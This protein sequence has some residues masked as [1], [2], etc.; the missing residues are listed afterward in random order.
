[1]SENKIKILIID[2]D[3]VDRMVIKRALKDSGLE[4]D[5]FNATDMETGTVLAFEEE[6]ACIFLDYSLPGNNGFEF[7]ENYVS[8][9]GNS[10]VILVTSSE[11][12]TIAIE[13]IKKGARDF[14]HK[15]QITADVIRKILSTSAY[16]K[17]GG[18]ETSKMPPKIS[19]LTTILEKVIS[20]SPIII[21]SIDQ[22]GN[23]TFLKGNGLSNL[24][25][26][27]NEIIGKSIFDNGLNLPMQLGDYKNALYGNNFISIVELG[28]FFY[29][30]HYIPVFDSYK[31]II[32]MNGI[33]YNITFL[34]QKE[35]ELR[36]TLATSEE[37][38]K[39][40]DSFLANMSHEVRTPI[41]GI[42]NLTDILLKT[43]ISEEQLKYLDAIKKSA[44]SLSVI[45]NDILDLSKI[46]AQK[47]RFENA[48]FNLREIVYSITEIFKPRAKEKNLKLI[49]N[50]DDNLSEFLNGDPVRLSQV[51]NNLLSNAIKFTHV[52]EVRMDVLME[53]KNEKFYLVTFRVSDTG[54]GIPQHK[55]TSIFDSFSQA[56]DDITRKYGG[57]GLGLN[58]CKKLVELQG[59]MIS[60]ESTPN[61]GSSF[62]FKL[63]F[64]SIS[65]ED[66][67][68]SINLNSNTVTSYTKELKILVVE[69]NDINRMVINIMTRDWNFKTDNAI[70]GA[71]AL[72][73]IEQNNYDVVLMDIEMPGL[74]GYQTAEHIRKKLVAPKNSIPILAMTAHANSSEKEK[75][76]DAGM[77]DYIS[78]PFEASEL[79]N[80]I[81]SLSE[82]SQVIVR[83]SDQAAAGISTERLTNLSFLRQLADN[84]ENFF[85]DFITLFLQNAPQ[86]ISDL[87]TSLEN[88]DWKGVRQA[89][90][91]IKPTLSY[92]GMKEE[93]LAAVRIEE[94]AK[95]LQDLEEIPALTRKIKDSCNKA[96]AELE[97]ELKIISI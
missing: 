46:E 92:L 29:Q 21:F 9:K 16:H 49:L 10:P 32:G 41:H 26:A 18:G 84:N 97:Q 83:G 56:G 69:D 19:E 94:S 39:I 67:S 80:K 5:V 95:N 78:K 28:N 66:V 81:I 40:K 47:M 48:Q 36:E 61:K 77:N 62:T 60:V 51:I 88:K 22:N 37:T 90:H 75:C 4:A 55:L 33:A 15:N 31:I 82:S 63:P 64:E 35:K 3:D 91:K 89:A 76:L 68:P 70:N 17:H 2:D 45:I 87:S 58:I 73:M 1:M 96:Y 6:F 7:L 30:V 86:T 50:Y 59:G 42:M 53:E 93:H 11:D 43:K 54:I 13:A 38:Q 23:F 65:F 24:N 12:E 20:D 57:T 8:K 79:K 14:I 27:A 71:A 25:L 72:E 44:D 85:K 34:K 74:N 52:G